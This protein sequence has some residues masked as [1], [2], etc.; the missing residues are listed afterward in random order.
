MSRL[1]IPGGIQAKVNR[2]FSG[3]AT[4]GND[5]GGVWKFD[6]ISGTT[7]NDSKNTNH[8]TASNARIFTT[9]AAGKRNT[10][11]DFTQG[12][13]VIS[14]ASHSSISGDT[15]SYSFWT[16]GN[17][18]ISSLQILLF[19]APDAGFNREISIEFDSSGY[20]QV[21]AYRTSPNKSGTVK[22]ISAVWSTSWKHYLIVKD[23]NGGNTRL[24]IYQNGTSIRQGTLSYKAN[25]NT[26]SYRVGAAQTNTTP[27]FNYFFNGWLDE[28]YF[29]KAALT[30]DDASDLYA[31]GA[32]RFY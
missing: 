19:K 20:M 5:I 16:K 31:D 18:T 24:T 8:G 23:L 15:M 29:W 6:E 12:N 17:G 4:L 25:T 21:Q 32:G 28:M 26:T 27:T 13:D 7:A 3:H 1:I 10:C 30:A 22:T 9:E 14:I 2:P 11:A